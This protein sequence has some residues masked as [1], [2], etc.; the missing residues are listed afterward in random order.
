MHHGLGRE[1]AGGARLAL[2]HD[3]LAEP[4]RHF[5]GHDAGEDVDVPARREAVHHFD[6]VTGIGLREHEARGADGEQR[7]N[8]HADPAHRRYRAACIECTL[9]AMTRR[10]AAI[11]AA[12]TTA[13]TSTTIAP[14]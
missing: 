3:R 13:A 12:C 8:D 9:A 11:L 10:S 14:A 2:D 4:I 7:R 1:A 5:L 6:E